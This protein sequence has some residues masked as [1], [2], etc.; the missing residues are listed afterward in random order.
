MAE[1]EHD[2]PG[3]A[4]AKAKARAGGRGIA[5][6]LK[7]AGLIIVA[8]FVFVLLLP[9]GALWAR[10]AVGPIN[11]PDVMQSHLEARI[12][13]AMV[14]GGMAA[15]V[16]VGDMTLALPQGSSAPAIE[17]RDVVLVPDDPESTLRAAFP[18]VRL[19]LAP[20]PL[21]R[22]QIRLQRIVVAQATLTLTRGA[23]G[24][25]DLDFGPGA[26]PLSRPDT[27]LG[28][29]TSRRSLNDTLT[30][31]DRMF[32]SDAFSHL[33]DVRGEQMQV[34]FAD[35]ASGRTLRLHGADA[36][37]TRDA[38]ELQL[39]IEGQLQGRREAQV[40]LAMTRD[41]AR[42]QTEAVLTFETLGARDLAAMS[43]AL[44]GLERMR[45][46]INGTV[47]AAI[48]DDGT[49]GSLDAAVVAGPG[50]ITLPNQIEPLAFTTVEAELSFVPDTGRTSFQRLLVAADALSFTAR[51]HVD[52]AAEPGVY[53]GQFD[54]SDITMAPDG[55]Y[56]APLQIDGAVLD[57]RL[58][59]GDDMRLDIGQAT[60]FDDALRATLSGHGV[61]GQDGLSL[62]LDVRV[63]RT[64]AATVLAYWPADVF[65]QTRQW[66]QDRL[67]AMTLHGVDFALRTQPGQRTRHE[68][69]FDFTDADIIALET[70]PPILG[71]SGFLRLQDQ[72]FTLRL[73]GGGMAAPEKGAVALAGTTMQI[74]DVAAPVPLAEFGLSLA[75][76]VNDVMHVLAGPPFEVLALS[77][78]APDDIGQ[79]QIAADATLALRLMARPETEDAG[80]G[81]D[82]LNLNASATITD[83]RAEAL[84]PE[85]QLTADR[86]TLTLT[87]EQLAIGG[88]AAVDGVPVT[89]QWR[90]ALGPDA[91]PGST[92][93]ARVTLDRAALAT[94]G[95]DLPE[96]FVSGRGEAD[97]TVSLSAD[98]PARV[99]LRSDLAGVALSIAP[100]GWSMPA[101]RTGDF[102]ADITL[103]PTPR[104]DTLTLEGA[105]MSLAGTVSFT[106]D[107]RLDRFSADRFRVGQW[108]DVQGA[109]I[110]R[111][112][113]APAI[114]VTGG[115]LDFR[116][117]PSLSPA[118][119]GTGGGSGDIGPLD[120][121]L[122]T[123]QITEGV[124]LTGLRA[125]LDGAS[126]SGQFRG[127][128]NGGPPVSGQLVSSPIGPSV[129][130][131]SD[132]GG[133]V[134][135]A[136]NIFENIHNGAFDL[137]LTARPE[138]GQYDGRLTIAGPRLRDAPVMAELLNLISVVGLLEQL[139]GEGI[140]L[141]QVEAAFRIT[142]SAI[143]LEQ[144]AALGPSLGVSMDGAYDVASA[145][146]EMQGVVS[147]LFMV[148]GLLGGL[149]A[150]RREGLFGFN[151][152]LIGDSD[153]TNVT[154]NPL[155]ILTPGIF[156][157]IFRAPPP[158]F[159][160]EN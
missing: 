97:I 98:R 1:A 39:N 117:M 85:R 6:R 80:P 160:R 62:A 105:G 140:N 28:R 19:R 79:G 130:L 158:D 92:V 95:V 126:M 15:A 144:G 31:L 124:S 125:D 37:L 4:S 16:R 159:T 123:L 2:A 93:Q 41:A 22:G 18:M 14:D 120:I 156:R 64:D 76:G 100:L 10:L 102:A 47:T 113:Q 8:V 109:L 82:E 106:D 49:L 38:Q 57:L 12:N 134:L 25:I 5:R 60:F 83:Y 73:D 141:G 68:V 52:V 72:H 115:V 88:P 110:G 151:Y 112:T 104:I 143:V 131:Q 7:R 89:G 129:R 17:F 54:V 21:L 11:V 152:R 63:D 30:R 138:A 29:A 150:P 91:P 96:W 35:V 44:G 34:Q 70:A 155:S 122:N 148:N 77:D 108:L 81:L 46:P 74:A 36:R 66:V 111:G 67:P 69:S 99:Q 43:P 128:V 56:D 78:L 86:L 142:P 94:F 121:R 27:E 26:D 118:S 65:P 119:G 55:L 53:T 127:L 145:R 147:P 116:T 45:A 20:E 136:A 133:A 87:P 103:G 139:S 50:D 42:R 3:T 114:E 154:V 61:V 40:T 59:L 84:I 23:D 153:G 71:A 132:D 9:L 13:G 101:A 48:L 32:A 90:V 33:E 149:L 146:Y 51:G 75:G 58:I 137:I 107:G 157:E 24:R 135:R